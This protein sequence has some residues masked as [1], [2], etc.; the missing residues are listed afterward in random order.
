MGSKTEGRT[1]HLSIRIE[2]GE[3]GLTC[4]VC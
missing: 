1:H 2:H 4:W 3:N